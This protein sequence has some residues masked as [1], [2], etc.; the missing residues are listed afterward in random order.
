MAKRG[1]A[2]VVREAY[3]LDKRFR[4]SEAKRQGA[5]DLGDL[6]CLARCGA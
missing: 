1:V 6:N 5:P 4:N 3:C 2:K